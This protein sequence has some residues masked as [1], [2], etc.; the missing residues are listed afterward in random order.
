MEQ[1]LVHKK[2]ITFSLPNF[3][4]HWPYE[5]LLHP[6]FGTVDVESATWVNAHHLFNDKS[7][8]LFDASLFGW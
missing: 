7:Q 8:N 5:R 3:L 1:H 2:S 6:N 4:A